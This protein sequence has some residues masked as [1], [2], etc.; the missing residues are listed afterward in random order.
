MWANITRMQT[1]P[2]FMSSTVLS[3]WG[4]GKRIHKSLTATRLQEQCLNLMTFSCFYLL[5]F[6]WQS[7]NK[8]SL[9]P[10]ATRGLHCLS[11]DLRDAKHSIQIYICKYKNYK[12]CLLVCISFCVCYTWIYIAQPLDVRCVYSTGFTT[13]THKVCLVRWT[14]IWHCLINRG[15][16]CIKKKE[17][18]KLIKFR[19]RCIA[20]LAM[21]SRR[22]QQLCGQ[23][24]HCV[25][26]CCLN[27]W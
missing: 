27:N 18:S 7:R 25:A 15:Q 2:C 4:R 16:L 6:L 26:S 22:C 5:M 19:L 24:V 11:K 14:E 13:H 12:V 3:E 10:D 8:L 21:K 9:W 20:L 1:V 23:Q 17:K